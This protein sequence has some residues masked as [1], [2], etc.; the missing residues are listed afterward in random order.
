MILNVFP[1]TIAFKIRCLWIRD[2]WDIGRWWGDTQDFILA[3]ISH[4]QE[5]P[6][7]STDA[8]SGLRG[9]EFLSKTGKMSASNNLKL[10]IFIV[11]LLL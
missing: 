6:E 7:I 1:Y 11:R 3:W 4:G 5:S 2:G 8:H 9:G 10:P